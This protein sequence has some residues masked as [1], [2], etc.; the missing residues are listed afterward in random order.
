MAGVGR[1]VGGGGVGGSHVT[2]LNFKMSRVSVFKYF[3][4]L[5]ATKQELKFVV[6]KPLQ[7]CN[8]SVNILPVDHLYIVIYN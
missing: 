6:K 4:S 1:G 2:G 7:F 8:F 3:M 5:S